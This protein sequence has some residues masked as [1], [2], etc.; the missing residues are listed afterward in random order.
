MAVRAPAISERNEDLEDSVLG[1][2]GTSG[3]NPGIRQSIGGI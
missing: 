1:V 3:G 2:L